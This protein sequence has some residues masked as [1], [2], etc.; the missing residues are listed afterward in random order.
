M[1]TKIFLFFII[2]L[3]VYLI[4]IG[5][6]STENPKEIY[7]SDQEVLSLITAW[8][9]QVGRKP[10]DD[11]T[12]RIINNLIDEEILYREA[13]LLG[14][15]Q[16]DRIIKRR[17]AQKISFLK[18]ETLTNKPSNEDLISYYDT[19]KDNYFVKPSYSFTHFF[20]SAENDSKNRS[21]DAY[22]KLASNSKEFNSDPFFLGKNFI[23]KNRDEISRNF[24]NIF[25]LNFSDDITLNEWIGPYKSSFGHHIIKVNQ[26]SPGFYPLIT[27]VLNKVEVD[28]LNENKDKAV[29]KYIE[30]VKSEYTI[31]VNQNL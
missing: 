3:F 7:I 29:N 31:F 15:D 9:S 4:D 24:G 12:S 13:L 2:G 10:T 20:F 14:L 23:N 22:N 26:S 6:N 18:Q 27:E 21:Q 8:Q 5:L 30:E 19:N 28:L 1:K 16:E 17:L 11:E 25:S